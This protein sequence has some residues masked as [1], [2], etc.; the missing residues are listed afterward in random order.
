MPAVCV[1][2]T[3]AIACVQPAL[4]QSSLG[5]LWSGRD[6]VPVLERLH[7]STADQARI[8]SMLFEDYE[9]QWNAA[10]DLL[11]ERLRDA[12]ADG[13][14][15]QDGLQAMQQ[16]RREHRRLETELDG[17][18]RLLLEPTRRREWE[19][20]RL[21]QLRRARMPLGALVGERVDLIDVVESLVESL[22]AGDHQ[23]IDELLAD[24]AL[25][26]DELLLKR[27]PF[28]L[29]G[30]SRYRYLVMAGHDAEAMAYLSSWVSL[31]KAIRVGTV[32][33][34]NRIGAQL[35]TPHA[36]LLKKA[37]HEAVW[38]RLA[39]ESRLER[40]LIRAASDETLAT[41]IRSILRTLLVDYRR[42]VAEL[43]A[44][45]ER[46]EWEAAPVRL[47]APIRRRLGLAD[48]LS[49]LQ[50]HVMEIEIDRREIEAAYMERVAELLGKSA[51][52]AY[53]LGPW[54]RPPVGPLP[55]L[56]GGTGGPDTPGPEPT[57]PARF[58]EIEPGSLGE[59]IFSDPSRGGPADEPPF[60]PGT[61]PPQDT[62]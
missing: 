14:P 48:Q 50:Q 13:D 60:P 35:A 27:Q 58:P 9:I 36:D 49:P 62:P 52:D 4:A 7:L 32:L 41:A 26:I 2:A 39:R 29:E 43:L 20:L 51:R 28:D 16:F 46:I 15:E 38:A 42:D 21:Q 3:V 37:V 6:V 12:S 45:R 8:I 23:A 33:A 24:W 59:P 40:I 17:D 55:G 19:S 34:A 54:P 57:G 18:V 47:M 56:D 44:E 10:R 1:C 30:P 11:S 22:P 53:P 61:W 25:E 5:P 31:R